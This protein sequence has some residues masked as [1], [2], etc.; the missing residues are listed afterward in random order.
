MHSMI[1]FDQARFR[2]RIWGHM[3][4]SLANDCNVSSVLLIRFSR[5]PMTAGRG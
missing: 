5:N 4:N 2:Y 1:K 3:R